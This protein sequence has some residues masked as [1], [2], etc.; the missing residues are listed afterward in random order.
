M[1]AHRLRV[2]KHAA[3]AEIGG[4]AGADAL[5]VSAAANPRIDGASSLRHRGLSGDSGSHAP[6]V[7][8]RGPTGKWW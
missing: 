2:L 6:D 5:L 7:S 8:G 3:I 1:G 4:D